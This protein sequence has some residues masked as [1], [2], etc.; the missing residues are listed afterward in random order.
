MWWILRYDNVT[1]YSLIEIDKIILTNYYDFTH[2][3][4]NFIKIKLKIIVL[5]IKKYTY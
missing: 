1:F 2:K 3:T 4:Q 5:L